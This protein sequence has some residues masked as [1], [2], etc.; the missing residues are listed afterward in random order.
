MANVREKSVSAKVLCIGTNVNINRLPH[1]Y[2]SRAID[3]SG[4][5]TLQGTEGM[6]LPPPPPPPALFS[7][8]GVNKFVEGDDLSSHVQED[9]LW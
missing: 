8:K 5:K 1:K 6:L 2:P 9:F 3:H 4:G 7:S